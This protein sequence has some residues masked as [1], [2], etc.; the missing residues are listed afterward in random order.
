VAA[1]SSEPERTLEHVATRN[2]TKQELDMKINTK[3][4]AGRSCGGTTIRT[5]I[6]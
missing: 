6:P 5:P 1:R 4:R 2:H 3:V